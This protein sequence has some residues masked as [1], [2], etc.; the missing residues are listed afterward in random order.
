MRKILLI[1]PSQKVS[2]RKDNLFTNESLVPSLGLASVAAYCRQ[3]GIAPHIIDMRLPHYSMT[4]VLEQIQNHSPVL[5]GITAFTTEITSANIIA[6]RIKEKYPHVPVVAGGPHSSQIPKETLGEF[7]NIDIIVIG[8]GEK[9]LVELTE[10]FYNKENGSIDNIEGIAYRKNGGIILTQPRQPFEDINELPL[11]AW[12]L[13]EL[14]YYNKIFPVSTSRGCPY[15]CYFCTPNYL[16]KKIRVKKYTNIANELNWLVD[17]FGA[18]QIQFADAT[19]GLLK[20]E[21]ILLCEE[22]I[23]KGIHKKISWDCEIRADSVYMALLKKMKEAGCGFLAFG[24]ES[25]NEKI[26]KDVVKK[27]ETKEQIKNAVDMAKKAGIKVRCFFILGHY[28]E[29]IGTIK[30]TIKF[31]LELNPHALSFGLMVPNPGSSFRKLAEEGAGGLK[32]LHNTWE[33]YQQFNYDCMASE[34]FSANELKKW[35]SNAYFTFYLHHPLKALGLF[36]S[37]SA[38]NYNLKG[39]ILL[40]IKLLKNKFKK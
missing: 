32:I 38:Y 20:D 23:K 9:A 13:F 27:G 33:N 29:T 11:P 35:Q 21:A 19:M 30:E 25:G 6:G 26:L 37:R 31:A 34:N 15:R 18:A 24:V 14:N 4:E 1:H 10:F 7:K 40:P 17:T 12:D 8:E 16:G 5:I 3:F 36:F 28:T 39:I 22:I 2:G